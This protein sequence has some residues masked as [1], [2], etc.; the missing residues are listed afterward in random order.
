MVTSKYNIVTFLPI[1]LLEMFSRV[2]YLYF[3]LQVKAA[4]ECVVSRICHRSTCGGRQ[5]CSM[6]CFKAVVQ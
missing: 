3:L 2:A 1:F 5:G 6:K 4:L